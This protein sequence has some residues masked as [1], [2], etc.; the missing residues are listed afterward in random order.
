MPASPW[1]ILG[2]DP[3]SGKDCFCFT[4]DPEVAALLACGPHGSATPSQLKQFVSDASRAPWARQLI[5][6]WDAPLTAAGSL[7]TR[8][9]EQQWARA[10]RDSTRNTAGVAVRGYAGLSHWTVS[11]AVLALPEVDG[12]EFVGRCCT[13]FSPENPTWATPLAVEVHPTLA[14]WVWQSATGGPADWRPYKGRKTAA[15]GKLDAQTRQEH[16]GQHIRWAGERFRDVIP[17]GAWDPGPALPPRLWEDALDAR[18]AWLLATLWVSGRGVAF[19]H[20]DAGNGFLL[21]SSAAAIHVQPHGAV[22]FPGRRGGAA[23]R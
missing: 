6:A 11:Q 20:D 13:A 5:I 17:A 8:R 12:R 18:I 21:P 3:A 10:L 14:L 23:P 7:T 22:P 1:K 4:D 2:V 15:G 19:C 16:A 9:I